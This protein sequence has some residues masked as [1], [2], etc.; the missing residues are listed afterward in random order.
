M[1]IGRGLEPTTL[2]VRR[3]MRADFLVDT[4]IR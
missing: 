1:K 2:V 3:P 4:G